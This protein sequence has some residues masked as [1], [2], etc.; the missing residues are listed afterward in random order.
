M[1]A[2]AETDAQTAQI[3]ANAAVA[4]NGAT[5]SGSGSSNVVTFAGTLK[6]NKTVSN[7]PNVVNIAAPPYNAVADSFWFIN[8]GIVTVAGSNRILAATN[9]GLFTSAMDGKFV[10][11]SR[12]G[13]F[14]NG[15]PSSDG[16]QLTGYAHYISAWEMDL[17]A[18][19]AFTSPANATVAIGDHIRSLGQSTNHAWTTATGCTVTPANNGPLT[20]SNAANAGTCTASVA[21]GNMVCTLTSPG[22]W[23]TAAPVVTATGHQG[24][25]QCPVT[26]DLSTSGYGRGTDDT[27]AITSS[28]SDS[29]TRGQPLYVPAAPSSGNLAYGYWFAGPGLT[30]ND[31]A[32]ILGDGPF[33][34]LLILAPATYFVDETLCPKSLLVDNL[35]FIGGVGAIREKLDFSL[36]SRQLPYRQCG[37]LTIHG[38]GVCFKSLQQSLLEIREPL[39]PRGQ[40]PFHDRHLPLWHG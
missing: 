14:Y 39:H 11:L 19:A 2:Q 40:H 23:Y 21:G 3:T 34:S 36:Y 10:V 27:A 13:A 37:G 9:G 7:V 18:D 28:W 1:A 4:L 24:S 38:Y 16:Q 5:S 15:N 17:Y 32:A 20:Y 12:A 25:F 33:K 22:S 30:G 31:K 26:M 35:G 6:S 8:N 29:I